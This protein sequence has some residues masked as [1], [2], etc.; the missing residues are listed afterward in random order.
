VASIEELEA[1]AN[2]LSAS[3]DYRVLRRL[4]PRTRCSSPDG[5]EIRRGL[6]IDLETTGLDHTR[7]E[8][9]EI[10]MVPFTYA[11]DGRIFDIGEP[12]QA[13][14]QPSNPIPTAITALTG[15]DDAMVAGKT[16]DPS[17]VAAFAAPAALVVAHH[18]AFDRKFSERF[19]DVFKTKA[20]A[21]SMSQVD[22]QAAGFEG[23]KLTYLAAGAGFFYDRHRAVQDCHAAIALLASPLPNGSLPLAQLLEKARRPTV[24]IWAEHSPFELKDHLKAR[25][26]RWNADATQAPR[27]WYIDVDEEMHQAEITFL[28]KEIYQREIS[29][30]TR[31]IT[32]YDRFSDRV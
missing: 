5:A 10:A 19:S 13:F 8:I 3:P 6:C 17:D 12:F 20:W 4:S 27:A 30:L 22:W 15:I 24:R 32:A 31:R 14:R 16:I 7:D 18:A 29:P 25:G 9:I 2:A 1:M 21:C 26:Y 28:T 11:V 23:T